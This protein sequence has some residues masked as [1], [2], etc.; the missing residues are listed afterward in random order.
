M[1]NVLVEARKKLD[2]LKEKD[3]LKGKNKKEKDLA[4]KEKENN[5]QDSL[6]KKYA[7]ELFNNIPNLIKKSLKLR[8]DKF[9][10]YNCRKNGNILAYLKILLDKENIKYEVEVNECNDKS[11]YSDKDSIGNPSYW[12]EY[13]LIIYI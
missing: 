10:L 9:I 8:K 12:T 3:S 5:K 4:K 1:K 13:D 6:D 2:I 11:F 7:K